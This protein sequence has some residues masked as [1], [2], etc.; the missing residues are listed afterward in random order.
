MRDA[1]V[2]H[3]ALVALLEDIYLSLE[4][5]MPAVRVE[6]DHMTDQ[7]T[8][9]EMIQVHPEQRGRGFAS[10]ALKSLCTQADADKRTLVVSP[11]GTDT[12]LS[13][14]QLETWFIQ[15]GFTPNRGAYA[16]PAISH[17]LYRRP[18]G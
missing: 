4:G 3:S 11:V 5:G 18:V 16:D 10:D 12:G 15:H 1:D 6:I 13:R 7:T 14:G 17:A 2:G 8:V 9:I